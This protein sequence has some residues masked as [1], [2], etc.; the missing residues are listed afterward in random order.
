MLVR[1][2]GCSGGIGGNLRTTSMLVDQ[3]I[4]IDAGTG[5]GDLSLTELQMVDHVF[6]THSHLDHVAMLPFL[7]DTVGG[8]RK[9]PIMVYAT[10]QTLEILR[11]HI[12][13]WKSWPDFSRIP[14]ERQP[15]LKFVEVALGET[16]ELQGRRITA[17]PANHTV[18]AVGYWIDSGRGSLIFT[19]DTTEC[20]ELWE[21]A[22]RIENLRY[23]IIETA[24][25]NGERELAIASKHLWPAKLVE[26]LGCLKRPARIYITHLKPGEG[27]ITMAEIEECAEPFNPRML[28]NG[29]VF[30]L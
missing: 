20:P 3:D 16:V 26:E 23:V 17:V 4:L 11:A 21:V 25:H 10:A 14:D 30:K 6:L 12:F 18:P 15:F 24:F 7:V 8:M 2:L 27:A 5:V 9:Q 28:S 19:G 29:H 1:V 22:N 13:N